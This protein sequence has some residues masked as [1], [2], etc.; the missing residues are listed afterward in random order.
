MNIFVGKSDCLMPIL[1][2]I[3]KWTAEIVGLGQLARLQITLG[4]FQSQF[5]FVAEHLS[6]V[7][8]VHMFNF[9]LVAY[10]DVVL[11]LSDRLLCQSI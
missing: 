1:L 8:E 11:T 2:Q 10:H 7:Q 4:L 6:F 3:L 5:H 9:Q